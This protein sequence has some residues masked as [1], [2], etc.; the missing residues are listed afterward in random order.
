MGSV[1]G[2]RRVVSL[3]SVVPD[4]AGVAFG[5]GNDE[6]GKVLVRSEGHAGGY[7]K[8][9]DAHER[10]ARYGG[11]FVREERGKSFADF[12]ESFRGLV[13]RGH[14]REIKKFRGKDSADSVA[15]QYLYTFLL[16]HE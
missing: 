5:L 10:P 12:R 2:V 8:R 11:V 6:V 9:A 7:S 13:F 4:A 16:I 1:R 15:S 14:K 3:L